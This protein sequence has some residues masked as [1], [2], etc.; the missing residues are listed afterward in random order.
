[1]LL[2][3]DEQGH[4]PMLVDNRCSIYEHRPRSCRT[5]DCRIFP[6]AGVEVDDDKPLIARRV[7]RWRFSFPTRA[8][9]EQFEAVQAAAKS[10]DGAAPTNATARALRAIELHEAFLRPDEEGTRNSRAT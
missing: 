7:E 1:M 8:D 2:G 5:Y 9:R 3:Y 4:C 10:P 6:A